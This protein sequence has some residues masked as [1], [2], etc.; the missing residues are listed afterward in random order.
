MR[1]KM[2][3]LIENLFQNR[4]SDS[5]S[6]LHVARELVRYSGIGLEALYQRVTELVL[7]TSVE[8]VHNILKNRWVKGTFA[9]SILLPCTI[10]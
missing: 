6:Q 10:L 2:R 4:Y 8:I 7:T 1:L 9:N 3:N 5:L